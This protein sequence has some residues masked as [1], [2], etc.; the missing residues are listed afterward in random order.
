LVDHD[1]ILAKAASVKKRLNRINQK[2]QI[3]KSLFREDLDC[4]EIILFNLQMAI[5]ECVDIASHVI[6]EEGW[7]VPGS[8]NEMFYLLE[9]N[10][11]LD[12]DL[13]EKMVKCV[14]FRNILVHEYTRIELDLVH[15]I[16][17]KDIH[18]LERYLKA[19]FA[20]LEIRV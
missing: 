19:I 11:Y 2:C 15:E 16:A 17:E 7:G 10:S 4:Q 18:D 9:E 1:L 6:S 13:T 14:G 3:E 8:T 12:R 5:Q 20:K